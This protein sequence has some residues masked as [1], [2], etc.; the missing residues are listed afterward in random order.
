MRP[1]EFGALMLLALIWGASFLF[2]RVAVT[3]G[4]TPLTLVDVPLGLAAL[5][6]LPLLIAR[7]R[8]SSPAAPIA[9]RRYLIPLCVVAL[10]NAA[11][12]YFLIAF[13]EERIAS[14]TASILNA[15]TPLF[16]VA[17]TAVIPGIAHE[18][19]TWGRVIGALIG[20]AGVI[21]LVGPEA[22]KQND[23]SVGFFACL[24]GAASYA[25]GGVA[26][27]I[28]LRGAPV[29]VQAVGVN[30]A[31]FL[32]LLPIVLITG[33][34]SQPPSTAA[35]LSVLA[36]SLLGTSVALLLY[37]WLLAR[38]GVTRTSIVTYLLPG[39]ALIWGAVLL[40]EPI[41]LNEALGLLLILIGIAAIN[42]VYAA[43]FR[44]QK[45]PAAISVPTAE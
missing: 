10:V 30:A 1:R 3:Q 25:V 21:V 16:A 28:G 11:L 34:P 39:T 37:Y 40:S 15:S 43:I 38:V 32:F 2:I 44:R 8:G 42:N 19:L 20:F 17:L 24:G 9:W 29:I 33:L 41:T 14:G 31:G 27:R 5:G 36:L 23:L 6:L 45:T 4:F 7:R 26:A 35:I 13:G 22:F 12:P 18:R